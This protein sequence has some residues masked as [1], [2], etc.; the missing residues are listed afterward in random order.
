MKDFLTVQ[1]Q[2]L[3]FTFSHTKALQVTVKRLVITE[4]H[5]LMIYFHSF[6]CEKIF[7]SHRGQLKKITIWRHFYHCCGLISLK[8]GKSNFEE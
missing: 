6:R 5:M 2:T 4:H 8:L 1:N 3:S 7:S